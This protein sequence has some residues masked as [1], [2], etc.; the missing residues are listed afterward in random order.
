[1]LRTIVLG[2]QFHALL[3]NFDAVHTNVRDGEITYLNQLRTTR[4]G[5]W[6]YV[7]VSHLVRSAAGDPEAF[8]FNYEGAPE[9]HVAFSDWRDADG[10]R[11]PFHI[12][13][14][15][16]SNA[17]DYSFTVIDT[18]AAAPDWAE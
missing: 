13:I 3:L 11:L 15:D 12:V 1:M 10:E 6:P 16:G 17:F 14:N 18:Q 9:I 5:D 7:G 8:V 4:D 2:H